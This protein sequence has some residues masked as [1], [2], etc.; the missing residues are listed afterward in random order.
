MIRLLA[1]SF[2][3]KNPS[4]KMSFQYRNGYQAYPFSSSDYFGEA[5]SSLKDLTPSVQK[6]LARVYASLSAASLAAA[7]GV[8][9]NL[10]YNVWNNFG[11]LSFLAG[12]GLMM[13]LQLTPA[14]P[15]NFQ[16]RMTYL[17]LFGLLQGFSLSPF[18]EYLI[19][20]NAGSVILSAL[21][22]TSLL[23]MSFSLTALNSRRRSWLYLGG[24][25]ASAMSIMAWMSLFSWFFGYGKAM[26]EVELFGGLLLFCGY[27]IFDTQVIVEKASAGDY[28]YIRHSVDLF[29]D[30]VS[31]FIR[32]LMIIARNKEEDRKNRKKRRS[33]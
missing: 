6:H 24:T 3:K 32:I 7:T 15:A 8:F 14:T 1:R 9:L 22:S 23:F 26:F 12:F 5:F 13:G 17:L 31:I 10:K 19:Q 20:I 28:D 4:L 2:P 18:I 33:Y 16:I 30:L 25:L 11:F 21:V 27:V 29:V